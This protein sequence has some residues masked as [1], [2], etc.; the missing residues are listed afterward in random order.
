MKLP[1]FSFVAFAT[2]QDV[3]KVRRQPQKGRDNLKNDDGAITEDD[4]LAMN[5][6]WKI[7]RTLRI[8]ASSRLQL[9]LTKR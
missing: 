7:M 5:M 3:F 2:L 9:R 8:K 1:I 4:I 6:T